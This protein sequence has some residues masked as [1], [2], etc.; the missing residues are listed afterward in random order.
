VTRR[1]WQSIIDRTEADGLEFSGIHVTLFDD[2]RFHHSSEFC[3]TGSKPRQYTAREAVDTSVPTWCECGGWEGT[4]LGWLLHGAAQ[5][6]DMLDSE[7]DGLQHS[8]WDD[9]WHAFRFLHD[10]IRWGYRT[11]DAELEALRTETKRAALNVLERSRDGLDRRELERRIAAQGLRV[12]VT[13]EE[14]T[15]LALWARSK[16][17]DTRPD[18]AR[19]R[20]FDVERFDLLLADALVRQENRLVL[21]R[22][23]ATT[24]PLKFDI[25]LPAEIALYLWALERDTEKTL[26]LHVP[27]AVAEGLRE[28]ARKHPRVQ[29]ASEDE[30]DPEVLC[31]IATLADDADETNIDI[32]AVLQTAR[33]L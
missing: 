15:D 2:Q 23:A 31:A 32:D 1:N 5:Q 8:R 4:R 24:S 17:V 30:R 28:L 14:A 11:E 26:L 29:V 9:V 25:T 18:Q 7:R 6:Y 12:P 16:L 21:I 20:N 10:G 13:A 3:G 27:G 22:G 19:P 33:L